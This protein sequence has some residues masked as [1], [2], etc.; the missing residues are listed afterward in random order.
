MCCSLN[1]P[2][3]A[4]LL[5]KVTIE[6]R[7]EGSEGISCVTLAA[8]T[9]PNGSILW[10]C[11]SLTEAVEREGNTGVRMGEFHHGGPQA[12]VGGLPYRP[13]LRPAFH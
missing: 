11:Q 5:G 8:G 9:S 6:Q 12:F 10:F 1:G 4:G 13:L 3:G 2:V 7:L